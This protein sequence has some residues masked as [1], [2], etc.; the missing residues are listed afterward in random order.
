MSDTTKRIEELKERVRRDDGFVASQTANVYDAIA[1]AES[2]AAELTAIRNVGSQFPVQV[3]LSMLRFSRRQHVACIEELKSIRGA[4]DEEVR[5][6]HKKIKGSIEIDYFDPDWDDVPIV[7]IDKMLDAAI[8]RGRERDAA[9]KRVKELEENHNRFL[10]EW[11]DDST[12][13]D[14]LE[15]AADYHI[16]PEGFL[17]TECRRIRDMLVKEM[18]EKEPTDG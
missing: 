7:L 2:L 3:L 14:R 16:D 15:D 4:G 5:K 18:E 8:S 1:L 11:F 6:W 17:S 10:R 9:L 13:M 12:D